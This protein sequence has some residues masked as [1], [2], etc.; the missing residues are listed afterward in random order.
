MIWV[1][2]KM[3]NFAGDLK[4]RIV[5]REVP[6]GLGMSAQGVEGFDGQDLLRED[7]AELAGSLVGDVL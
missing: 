5:C 6:F 4:G 1:G 7:M 3:A 2:V